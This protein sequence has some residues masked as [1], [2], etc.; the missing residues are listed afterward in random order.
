M[1]AATYGGVRSPDVTMPRKQIGIAESSSSQPE[2]WHL[3]PSSERSLGARVGWPATP[4]RRVTIVAT[5]ETI[6]CADYKPARRRHRSFREAHRPRAPA[7]RRGPRPSWGTSAAEYI[8][9][10]MFTASAGSTTTSAHGSEPLGAGDHADRQAIAAPSL[11]PALVM[12]RRSA[13]QKARQRC[14]E[15]GPIKAARSHGATPREKQAIR[16]GPEPG[17]RLAGPP[18]PVRSGP[19]KVPLALRRKMREP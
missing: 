17:L 9:M 18:V 12:L 5:A 16:Q 1:V 14:Q 2:M 3:V 6:L 19:G 15:V 4:H 8:A 13:A 11:R 7:A 10:R